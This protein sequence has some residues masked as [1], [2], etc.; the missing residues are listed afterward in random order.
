MRVK[1]EQG[2]LLALLSNIKGLVPSTFWASQSGGGDPT[3]RLDVGVSACLCRAA[4][5]MLM[6][7]RL[8]MALSVL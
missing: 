7:P 8:L 6:N 4:K 1:G 5:T 3:S 2:L